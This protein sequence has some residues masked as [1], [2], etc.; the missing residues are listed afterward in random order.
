L[1]GTIRAA[2]S[3][4]A[5]LK[6]RLAAFEGVHVLSET[7]SG[8]GAE[9]TASFPQARSEEIFRLIADTTS[10]RSALELKQ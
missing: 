10:G 9:I 7:F 1:E 5:I 6:A 3:D 2:F 8:A 4:L